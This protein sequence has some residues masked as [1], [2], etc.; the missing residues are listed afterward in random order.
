MIAIHGLL[1]GQWRDLPFAPFRPGVE[2]CI[3]RDGG[4]DGQT[5]A[6]LRYQ[7]GASVPRH[8]HRG[9]ETIIVIEGEQSDENGAYRAGDVILNETG[10]I[11]TV[12]SDEGCVVLILWE[13]PV[14]ILT[15]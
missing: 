9:L 8:R 10:S 15:L 12:R 11:H 1:H 3:L 13:R 6:L 5:A 14:E 2:I 7:P 4:E